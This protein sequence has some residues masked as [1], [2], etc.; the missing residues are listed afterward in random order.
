MNNNNNND[1][2]N[3]DNNNIMDNDSENGK[4]TSKGFHGPYDC[5]YKDFVDLIWY[6]NYLIQHNELDIEVNENDSQYLQPKF[7]VYSVIIMCYVDSFKK[8]GLPCHLSNEWISDK[9]WIS[10]PGIQRRINTLVALGILTRKRFRDRKTLTLTRYLKI[11]YSAIHKYIA[12]CRELKKELGL[13]G[14]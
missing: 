5:L 2:N 13:D 9:L 12:G 14:N 7:D 8:N 4:N 1:N 3:I 10:A 11:N 6:M